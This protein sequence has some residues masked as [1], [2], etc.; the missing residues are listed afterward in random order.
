MS[1]PLRGPG[2]APLLL[3]VASV[4]VFK[5]FFGAYWAVFAAQ[6]PV[7]A[8]ALS[9]LTALCL[10]GACLWINPVLRSVLKR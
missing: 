7:V 5:Q 6:L 10:L 4:V 8:L 2:L 1:G 3:C 9:G